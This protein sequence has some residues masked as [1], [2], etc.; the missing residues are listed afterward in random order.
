MA[1]TVLVVDDDP[2]QRRLAQAVLERDSRLKAAKTAK[3][4]IAVLREMAGEGFDELGLELGNAGAI[5]LGIGR[6]DLAQLAGQ[7]GPG[8]PVEPM[9]PAQLTVTWIWSK[10]AATRHIV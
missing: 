8:T 5:G 4:R 3:E 10:C 2:T 1:K 6:S 7:G 9:S